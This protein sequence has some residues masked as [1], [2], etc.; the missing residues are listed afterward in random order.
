MSI[1]NPMV[2]A[3]EFDAQC[4]DD[5]VEEGMVLRYRMT[6]SRGNTSAYFCSRSNKFASCGA[7][8]RRSP[9][10]NRARR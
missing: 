5:S 1:F 2:V 4:A 10:R 8:A 3:P 7:R 9:T 6:A